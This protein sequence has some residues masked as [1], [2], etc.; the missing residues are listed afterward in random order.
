MVTRIAEALDEWEHDDSVATVLLTGAG[1]RGYAPA[2]TS[3][4]STGMR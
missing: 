3:W 4:R 1:E 2:V